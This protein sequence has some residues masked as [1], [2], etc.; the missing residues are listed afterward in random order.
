MALQKYALNQLAGMNKQLGQEDLP[1][2][3]YSEMYNMILE[4]QNGITK[5]ITRDGLTKLT[6]NETSYPIVSLYSMETSDSYSSIVAFTWD[7]SGSSND[8]YYLNL[9][10]GASSVLISSATGLISNTFTP[11]LPFINDKLYLNGQYY[12]SF[13]DDVTVTSWATSIEHLILHNQRIIGS[14]GI[15]LFFSKVMATIDP[16]ISIFNEQGDSL[17]INN[18]LN[19]YDSVVYSLESIGDTCYVFT[20]ESIDIWSIP[21]IFSEIRLLE[22]INLRSISTNGICRVNNDIY[23]VNN[24]G[25]FNIKNPNNNLAISILDYWKSLI[26]AT[27]N[28]LQ[29]ES[30]TKPINTIYDPNKNIIL[31]AFNKGTNSIESDSINSVTWADNEILIFNIDLQQFVSR[32]TLFYG[33]NK[34][35]CFLRLKDNTIYVSAGKKIYKFDSTKYK[36]DTTDFSF[37]FK[38]SYLGNDTMYNFKQPKEFALKYQLTGL[39]SGNLTLNYNPNPIA[40]LSNPATSSTSVTI[41]LISGNGIRV[42]NDL[43]GRGR[44]CEVELT[45]TLNG[46]LSISKAVLTCDVEGEN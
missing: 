19:S 39:A 11:K 9:I 1:N 5:I 26:N 8:F 42:S 24:D 46:K 13:S 33:E 30:F 17:S 32:F 18:F 22:K 36:D 25:F 31:I 34:N 21:T 20:S 28:I 45:G 12:F 37:D 10:T 3:V 14:G 35:I 27:P 44:M 23:I 2:N 29:G 15:D 38:S 43:Q 6:T 16:T 7:F 41:P 40:D 4:I